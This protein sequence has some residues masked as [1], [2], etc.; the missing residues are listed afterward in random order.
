[1]VTNFIDDL[2]KEKFLS[3]SIDFADTTSSNNS[4]NYPYSI[5]SD[6]ERANFS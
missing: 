1:M 2:S 3:Q 4:N 6:E 5:I